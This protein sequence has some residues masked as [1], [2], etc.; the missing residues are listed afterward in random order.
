MAAST[1]GA[2]AA[3]ALVVLLLGVINPWIP[4]AVLVLAI[5]PLGVLLLGRLFKHAAPTTSG[6]AGPSV[7]STREASYDPVSDPG[8]RG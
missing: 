2:V 7:P 5:V 1:L 6:G 8:E 3:I 4:A